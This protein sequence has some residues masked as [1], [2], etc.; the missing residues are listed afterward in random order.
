MHGLPFLLAQATP[1]AGATETSLLELF[2]KAEG[3]L[4]PLMA[5]LAP[6]LIVLIG[7]W[8]VGHITRLLKQIFLQ[9]KVDTT[10]S[11]FLANLSY[12]LLLLLV[13]VTA[14]QQA[15]VPITSIVAVIGASTLAIGLALQGF[16]TNFA[17]GV[18]IVLF[19]YF[20][21][22]DY[23]EAGGKAGTV[24]QISILETHLVT[25][26]NRKVI[27]PNSKVIGDAIV[28]YNANPTRRLDL[29]FG[30]AY[31]TDLRRAKE[32]LVAVLGEDPRVLA[33]PAP[34]VAVGNL[35]ESTVDLLAR[36]WVKNDDYS[37]L[38]YALLETV[39]LRFDAA[40]ISLAFPQRDV[41]IYHENSAPPGKP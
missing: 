2:H 10:L 36:P 30:V 27:I 8:L 16:L 13:I 38:Q 29:V 7:I 41:H 37:S 24:E 31:Q 12:W 11:V 3:W 1:P 18:I 26:D 14:V 28:N 9:R 33:N 17:A 35:G 22:G 25:P 21:V 19:R 40:G 20:R 4:A 5:L 6:I 23:I 15:G 34:L 39:K 32:I